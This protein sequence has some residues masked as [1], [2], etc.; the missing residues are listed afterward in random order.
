VAL[1][2]YHGVLGRRRQRLSDLVAI[3]DERC[4]AERDWD[5]LPLRHVE[6][7][8]SGHPYAVDLDV[9][10]RASL[11]HLLLAS[12][13]PIGE[14]T[15]RGWLLNPAP[16]ENVRDRQSAAAELRDLL[17]MRD[18]LA[19]CGRRIRT[20]RPDV[21][22]FL[23]WAEGTPWLR[24]LRGVRWAARICP[25]LF[26]VLLLADHGG[27]IRSGCRSWLR[28]RS[29]TGGWA[30]APTERSRGSGSRRALE[31][32]AEAMQIVVDAPL[33]SAG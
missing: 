9:T 27:S 5:R 11:M 4:F 30:G 24:P 10:G 19:V 26:W 17:D 22:P 15:L 29:S 7:A 2:T 28:T 32:Y 1:A 21:E 25:F 20:A 13:T 18:D 12:P 31:H 3:D 16:R 8:D 14:R 23:A 33:H 6:P